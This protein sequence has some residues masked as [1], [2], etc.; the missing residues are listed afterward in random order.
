MIQKSPQRFS[1]TRTLTDD[2]ERELVHAY[3]TTDEPV[4]SLAKRFGLCGGSPVS[5]IVKRWGV[6]LRNPKGPQK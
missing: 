3:A 6:P 4:K 2:R 5:V 1:R